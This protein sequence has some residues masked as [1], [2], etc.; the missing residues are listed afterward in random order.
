MLEVA[1]QCVFVANRMQNM[2]DHHMPTE[3]H[4]NEAIEAVIESIEIEQSG[5]RSKGAPPPDVGEVARINQRLRWLAFPGYFS[6]IKDEGP[7]A[8]DQVSVVLAD[9]I[10]TLKAQLERAMKHEESH[11][12]GTEEE[13]THI[14][15]VFLR[16]IPEVRRR[17]L[18]DE[19]AAFQGDPAAQH[20]DEAI[21]CQP[22]M[23]A[24]AVHRF[25]H[26]LFLL[27]VPLLPRMMAEAAHGSTGIDI[28][29]GA[30]IGEA[31]FIDHGTGVVIGETT[32]IGDRCTIYQGVTL[33]AAY[34]DR[35]KDGT[36]RRN[37][38][39]HPTLG[40][41]VTVFAGATILGGDTFIGSGS[42]VNGGV[43]LTKSVPEHS[44]VQG[45]K[46]DIRLRNR[47]EPI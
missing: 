35:N 37:Y 16:R 18:L 25:A 4:F 3:S 13:I 43:F 44:I 8:S 41:D 20:L 31:F 12:Q 1:L 27:N 24:L 34:F 28:H 38:K 19:Q 14:I 33:G 30:K 9:L 40:N 47:E 45:P 11:A 10:H 46:L 26:E 7:F 15:D 22:G 42:T 21:L 39:R 17:L 2:K 23:R 36:I 6:G 32:E 29:P 5:R